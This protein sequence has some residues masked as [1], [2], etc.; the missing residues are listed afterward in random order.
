MEC[1][2]HRI[3]VSRIPPGDLEAD[4]HQAVSEGR[5]QVKSL[6]SS[7]SRRNTSGSSSGK[8][9]SEPTPI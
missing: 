2:K 7:L 4:F 8:P 3:T 9:I 1:T 6:Q 5:R